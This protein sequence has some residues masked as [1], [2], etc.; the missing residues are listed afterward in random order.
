MIE[1]LKTSLAEE[2]ISEFFESMTKLGFQKTEIL[3]MIKKCIKGE[4]E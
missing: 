1:N 4:Q 2:K 3:A